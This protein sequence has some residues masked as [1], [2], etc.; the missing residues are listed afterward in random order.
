M[1]Q[2]FTLDNS[3]G[4]LVDLC[5][6]VAHSRN[7]TFYYTLRHTTAKWL[8]SRFRSCQTGWTC[9]PRRSAATVD[10]LRGVIF[11][12]R[13][14]LF[15]PLIRYS[16]SSS[17]SSSFSLSPFSSSL[18]S[19]SSSMSYQQPH[20]RRHQHLHQSPCDTNALA[21]IMLWVAGGSCRT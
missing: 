11:T 3:C 19:F 6:S 16:S 4:Y 18:S 1:V 9:L 5:V 20:C 8:L 7:D 15:R 10:E 17:S 14:G 13:A 21:Y 12:P 2:N